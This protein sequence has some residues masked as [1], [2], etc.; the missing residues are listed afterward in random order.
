MIK[1]K[2]LAIIYFRKI[3][4][5]KSNH[6]TAWDTQGLLMSGRRFGYNNGM[7][8]TKNMNINN[9]LSHRK[10]VDIYNKTKN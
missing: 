9:N 3:E 10:T 8:Q 2:D 1:N 4:L 6:E 5:T 7:L